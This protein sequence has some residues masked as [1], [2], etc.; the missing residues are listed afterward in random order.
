MKI[1][2]GR[3]GSLIGEYEEEAVPAL[4]E[5]GSLLLTDIYWHEGMAQWAPVGER[6][7]ETKDAAEDEFKGQLW[8]ARRI[9]LI[10]L[11][12]GIALSWFSVLEPLK[13]ARNQA[14]SVSTSLKGTLLVPFGLG[15]G[16]VYSIFPRFALRVLGLPEE[17]KKTMGAISVLLLVAGGA[18]YW[19]VQKKLA[20][21][22]YTS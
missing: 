17:R 8:P 20:D 22:G 6:W 11:G 16:F 3:N 9:G 7:R 18:L 2:F 12:C 1:S 19:Y 13:E 14:E 4:L 10:L 21:Y 5:S 15:L